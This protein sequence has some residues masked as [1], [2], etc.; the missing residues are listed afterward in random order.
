MRIAVST[1]VMAFFF[2]FTNYIF[3]VVVECSGE[4]EGCFNAVA[5]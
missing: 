2:Y 5:A 4:K 1:Q 3:K